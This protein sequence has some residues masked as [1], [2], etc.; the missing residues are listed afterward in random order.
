MSADRAIEI[1]K[2]AILLEK[3][4]HAF[5]SKVAQQAR[6]EAVKRFFQLMAEEEVNHIRILSEQFKSYLSSKKF[7]PR[8]YAEKGEF[9]TLSE[10]LTKDLKRQIAAADFEAAAV[11]A[12]MS[13]EKNAVQVYS[14]RASETRD[15]DEKALYQWLA[16]WET[17]HLNFLARIDR[18]LTE[19]IWH[20]NHF[21][22]F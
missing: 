11:A 12:A 13:M 1:L 2:S 20:D 18:E 9:N 10:I 15:P 16:E 14:S 22:P 3:R 17:R 8:D 4:G 7:Q 6:G 5:Y 21:W 19:E